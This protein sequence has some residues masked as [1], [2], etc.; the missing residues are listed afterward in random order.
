MLLLSF[1]AE[2][3]SNGSKDD[4]NL[5]ETLESVGQSSTHEFGATDRRIVY[6]T[7]SGKFKD[8]EYTHISSIESSQK[9]DNGDEVMGY[10]IGAIGIL[11]GL[12]GVV[13]LTDQPLFG[14][15]IVLAGGWMVYDAQNRL[16]NAES[17]EKQLIN[18][19]TGDEE[20]QQ[21]ELTLSPDADSNIGA[22]L[23]SILREHHRH[24]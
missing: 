16:E 17:T 3:V 18:F 10:L 13:T 4:I 14:F 15:A 20:T 12:G 24:D 11:G 2:S 22:E 19:I 9:I 5:S 23:S 6:L 7:S 21:L 8:L 1:V